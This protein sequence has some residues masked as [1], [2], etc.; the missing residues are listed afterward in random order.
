M[1]I[2]FRKDFVD[3]KTVKYNMETMETYKYEEC[4]RCNQCK[5]CF[6]SINRTS[7]DGNYEFLYKVIRA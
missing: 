7:K 2:F 1:Y 6:S 4:A 3:S 5:L